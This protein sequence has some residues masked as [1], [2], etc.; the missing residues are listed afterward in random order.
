MCES[1]SMVGREQGE[2]VW[3]LVSLRARC[4]ASEKTLPRKKPTRNTSRSS[5][6][7]NHITALSVREA[8]AEIPAQGNLR[9]CPL[10][11]LPLPI[12]SSALPLSP[13]QKSGPSIHLINPL[14]ATPSAESRANEHTQSIKQE[15][16]DLAKAPTLL[17]NPHAHP[18][19]PGGRGLS[20]WHFRARE[21]DSLL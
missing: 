17:P 10:F 8:D 7:S 9:S 12:P 4:L 14:A 19:C 6:T 2:P 16:T 13:T 15:A 1:H 3:L 11:R 20:L 18:S 5:P 21:I